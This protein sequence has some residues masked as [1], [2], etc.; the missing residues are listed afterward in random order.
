MFAIPVQ[1]GRYTADSG[2]TGGR[3]Y[4]FAPVRTGF[5]YFEFEFEKL[6]NETKVPKNTSRFIECNSVKFLPN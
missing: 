1:T 5:K 2:A 6:K 3:R 4:Q